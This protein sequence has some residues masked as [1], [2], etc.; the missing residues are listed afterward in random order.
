VIDHA[1]AEA[2]RRG[3]PAVVAE[4]YH[5][6]AWLEAAEPVPDTDALDHAERLG[7]VAD[8]VTTERQMAVATRGPSR[9]LAR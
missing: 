6:I 4:L 1:V 9:C 5:W 3:V 2:R 7:G 8:R